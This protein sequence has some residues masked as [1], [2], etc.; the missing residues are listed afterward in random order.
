MGRKYITN[1]PS[2]FDVKLTSSSGRVMNLKC[3]C[4]VRLRIIFYIV[5]EVENLEYS[6][7]FTV[8]V[9]SV[10]APGQGNDQIRSSHPW[11]LRVNS[12]T[13]PNVCFFSSHNILHV[14]KAFF[15][16]LLFSFFVCIGFGN[17][18]CF[19]F[20]TEFLYNCLVYLC[21]VVSMHGRVISLPRYILCRKQERLTRSQNFVLINFQVFN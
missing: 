3:A 18:N 11:M 4:A 5:L 15:F 17:F 2:A 6:L 12:R 16:F 21:V 10:F 9:L 8:F 7:F 13:F 20:V 1:L 19:R 14:F